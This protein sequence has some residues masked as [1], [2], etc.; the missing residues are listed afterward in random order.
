MHISE[1]DYQ[2]PEELIAQQP[3]EQ[4]DGSRMLVLDRGTKTWIDSEFLELPGFLRPNDVLVINNTRVFPARLVGERDPS[5][6]Q[7]EVLLVRE[8]EPLCWQVL[9]RSGQRLKQGA[10]LRFGKSKLQA[11][12]L[13]GPGPEL[14]QL[15][16][17]GSYCWKKILHEVGSV[18][19][20]P[21]IK[22]P[23]GGSAA[24]KARYQTVFARVEGAIA[25]PTAGLHFTPGM[26]E[27]VK[28]RGTQV[29]EIT[30][31]VSYGTFQPVRVQEI[32]MHRV[33]AELFEITDQAA[34]TINAARLSGGPVLAAA[35]T[36]TRALESGVSSQ[37]R[38]EAG[39]GTAKLT[40]T[41][42]YK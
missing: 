24:D 4:R 32:E 22:R 26:I 10:R 23:K 8:L 15:R 9:V 3:L 11:E 19:L 27:R 25:A 35:T 18:P 30:L 6:G 37:G 7:V 1:F 41:P 17:D 28:A 5:S 36:T 13:D 16:F 34:R 39:A 42:G 2:L 21:Y 20:P 14:R 40:I 31:H 38:V 29:V 33:A 12:M